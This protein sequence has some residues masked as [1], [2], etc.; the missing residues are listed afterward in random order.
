MLQCARMLGSAGSDAIA[1]TGTP[2]GWAGLDSEA[3]ARDRS[4]MLA[5]AAGVPAVMAGTAIIDGLRA[6][7]AEKV[8][9][10]TPYYDAQW[11]LAC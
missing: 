6:I 4:K 9:I 1:N 5:D 2:F 10:A 8:A 11:R 7:G 3:A